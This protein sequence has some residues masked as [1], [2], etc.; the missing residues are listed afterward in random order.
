MP[1]Q[2]SRRLPAATRALVAGETFDLDFRPSSY[3]D[4]V[5]PVASILR[6]IKGERRREIIAEVLRTGP[7][8]VP[9]E[10]LSSA[11]S[12]DLRTF[13]GQLHPTFMGGEYL[14]DLDRGATEIAR[15][16]LQ[17]TTMDVYSI[18]GR[19]IGKGKQVGRIR[20][21][22]VD[23][24]GSHYHVSPRS[25]HGPLSLG[26][27]IRLIDTARADEEAYIHS[28]YVLNIC[29]F[30][31]QNDPNAEGAFNA[32]R[33]VSVESMVYPQ[34]GNYYEALKREWAASKGVVWA[35]DGAQWAMDAGAM[36][37]EDKDKQAL[38]G[39]EPWQ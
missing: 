32:T 13:V 19:R 4:D 37:L 17:S 36:G 24:Y 2:R 39:K 26:E 35:F 15:I 25:A 29:Q 28:N 5:G 22:I 14:P 20:F 12:Y 1:A 10:M 34:L 38:E 31:W 27:I 18:R 30:Q 6:D 33:F 23:E 3:W 7:P 9:D 21:D 11:L 8:D 16:V